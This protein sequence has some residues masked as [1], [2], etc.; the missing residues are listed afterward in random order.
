MRFELANILRCRAYDGAGV[1][2]PIEN[3]SVYLGYA[4]GGSG[5]ALFL[6][7]L[8]LATRD[9]EPLRLG[10]EALR[11]ELAQ[12][13][14]LEEEF[15]SF[16]AQLGGLTELP[17]KA[18][19]SC[20]WDVGSAGVGTALVRYYFIDQDPTDMRWLAQL[21][22]DASRKYTAFPQLFRG[23]AGLGNFLL[24]VWQVTGDREHLLAAWQTAEGILL[25]GIEREQGLAF[26]GDQARRESADF[27]TG[28]AGVG[29][30]LNRLLK[31]ES[32]NALNFN[33]V[34]DEFLTGISKK[35]N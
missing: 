30:F 13:V 4:H 15:A 32:E 3:G 2:W 21:T 10:R 18:A 35:S 26:P 23:L 29:L 8:A 9:S 5:I 19:V 20:Y 12:A 16:P 27:A 7:Y 17:T 33:F 34:A 28:A 31:A 24:D 1:R 25:F 22:A 14:W 6:F 11:F